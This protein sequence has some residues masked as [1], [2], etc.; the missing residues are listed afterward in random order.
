M[1][2]IREEKKQENFDKDM[3]IY[4]GTEPVKTGIYLLQKLWHKENSIGL[5]GDDGLM[6]G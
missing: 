5:D 1:H 2:N 3:E 4:D 6:V